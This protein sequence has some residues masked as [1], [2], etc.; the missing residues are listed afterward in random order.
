MGFF[1]SADD[2]IASIVE[3]VGLDIRD[4]GARSQ[5][6][7]LGKALDEVGEEF[8]LDFDGLK[9]CIL[10][11][12]YRVRACVRVAFLSSAVFVWLRVSNTGKHQGQWVRMHAGDMTHYCSCC[13]RLLVSAL[14][15]IV[16]HH[17]GGQRRRPKAA[18]CAGPQ[19]RRGVCWRPEM[20]QRGNSI[21][22]TGT[23]CFSMP[24]ALVVLVYVPTTGS[25]QA[26]SACSC[27][28]RNLKLNDNVY[29]CT[30]TGRHSLHSQETICGWRSGTTAR[31]QRGPM[32]APCSRPTVLR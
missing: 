11:L 17:S 9:V 14:T 31:N 6:K 18:G 20:T 23:S 15:F 22:S 12:L 19:H 10:C 21:Y 16:G 24:W 2:A 26:L 4:G 32:T 5:N 27:Q 8:C 30:V 29:T 1:D 13:G 25:S 3:V 7:R 28:A